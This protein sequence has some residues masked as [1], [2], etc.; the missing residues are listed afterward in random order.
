MNDLPQFERAKNAS[1]DGW[2]GKAVVQGA[3]MG[4]MFAITYW[5]FYKFLQS[6]QKPDDTHNKTLA[7][8]QAEYDA[9][10]KQAKEMIDRT[11]AYIAMQEAQAKRMDAV[12][13][14]WEKQTGIKK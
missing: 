2:L 14:A 1:S 8:Q 10:T 6:T 13:A 12:I 3:V 7:R 4:L 9:Q 11:N 5:S